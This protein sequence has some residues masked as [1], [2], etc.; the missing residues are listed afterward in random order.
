MPISH[1]EIPL[2]AFSCYAISWLV[3][4]ALPVPNAP[5]SHPPVITHASSNAL[6][7]WSNCKMKKHERKESQFGNCVLGKCGETWMSGYCNF[8]CCRCERPPD[9]VYTCEQQWSWGKCN[10]AWMVEG[11]FC[12]ITCGYC[13]SSSS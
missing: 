4:H 1:P 13:D 3:G 11:F 10:E 5:M 12:S 2:L 8:S 6:G 9:S 7:E